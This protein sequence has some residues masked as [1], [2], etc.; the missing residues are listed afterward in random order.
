MKN[1]LLTVLPVLTALFAGLT[2][3]LFLGRNPSGGSVTVSIPAQ[4][5]TV[6]ADTQPEP[7]AQDAALPVNINT[8]DAAELAVLPGIGEVLAQRIV[9][10]RALHGD[11]TAP[12]QLTNVEGIGEGKLDAILEWITIGG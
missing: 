10:Y 4:A 11:F 6:P 3:G 2:L 8:A 5:Q 9:D 12:E 7:S 1:K